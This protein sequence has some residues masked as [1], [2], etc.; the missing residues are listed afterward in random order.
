MGE[1]IIKMRFKRGYLKK[2]G[3]L[4]GVLFIVGCSDT[5]MDSTPVPEEPK[6]ES[7]VPVVNSKAQAIEE[8]RKLINGPVAGLT[9]S[10]G[11]FSD[12]SNKA[13]NNPFIMK[14]EDW[15]MDMA[16]TLTL[17][18]QYINQFEEISPPAGMEDVHDTVLKGMDEFSFVVDN[19]PE[20][21]DNMDV[22]LMKQCSQAMGNGAQ[23]ISEA[24]A[25]LTN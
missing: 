20:A 16:L 21:I 6:T 7:V 18:E 12:L 9:E 1:G 11:T 5:S 8:Y 17:M 10:L 25:T 19:F 3:F 14:T 2:A 13:A 24:T 23:Y 22:D 4:L 15:L